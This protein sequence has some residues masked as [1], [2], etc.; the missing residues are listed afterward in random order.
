MNLGVPPNNREVTA[1]E[2]RDPDDGPSKP[3]AVPRLLGIDLNR[4]DRLRRAC[5]Q[6]AFFRIQRPAGLPP[7]PNNFGHECGQT[8]CQAMH[9]AIMSLSQRLQLTSGSA[10]WRKFAVFGGWFH[11]WER[12]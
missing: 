8:G 7:C 5:M 4:A 10:K 2:T 6:C 12:V 1:I 3:P 9:F 11:D